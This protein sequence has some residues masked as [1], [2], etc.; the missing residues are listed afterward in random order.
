MLITLHNRDI[1]ALLMNVREAIVYSA[2]PFTR[3]DYMSTFVGIIAFALFFVAPLAAIVLSRFGLA[4]SDPRLLLASAA[5]AGLWIA[6]L[7]IA[8]MA[9]VPFEHVIYLDWVHWIVENVDPLI[10]LAFFAGSAL[11]V[12]RGRL[13]RAARIVLLAIF[14]ALASMGILIGWIFYLIVFERVTFG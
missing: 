14:T 9:L 1:F 10:G 4:R 2:E 7:P 6:N 8:S 3:S 12:Q 11:A 5:A 13:R